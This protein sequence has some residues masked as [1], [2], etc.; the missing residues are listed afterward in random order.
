MS[1]LLSVASGWTGRLGPF[2]LLADGVAVS[3][4]GMTVTLVIRDPDGAL[5]TPGGTVTVNPDQVANPGKVV[6]DPAATDFV[7]V[8]GGPARQPFQIRWKVVDG[9]GKVVYFPNGDADEISV[10]RA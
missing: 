2:T 5:V 6:Y 4:T 1:Q 7:W 8:S 9:A 3:L 10:Y